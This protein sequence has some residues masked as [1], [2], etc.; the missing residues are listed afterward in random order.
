MKNQVIIQVPNKIVG[1]LKSVKLKYLW[2]LLILNFILVIFY[3]MNQRVPYWNT[4]Y[5][6]TSRIQNRQF[7]G[8]EKSYDKFSFSS[9]KTIFDSYRTPG[10]PLFIR[11]HNFL[12]SDYKYW[13]HFQ[14]AIYLASI[15]I[16]FG[17]MNVFGFDKYF[18]F[19]TAV[20]L[21]WNTQGYAFL[22]FVMTETLA[23][24]FMNIT[25][26]ALLLSVKSSKWIYQI[27]FA[28]TLFYMYQIRPNMSYVAFLV[29]FW[30]VCFEAVCKGYNFFRLKRT[31]LRFVLLSIFPLLIFGFIRYLY[32]GRYG[33]TT[34]ALGTMSG[35]AT[36]YLNEDNVLKL[37]G[38]SR[39]IADEILRR[40]RKMRLSYPCNLAPFESNII[41]NQSIIETKSNCFTELGNLSYQVAIKY[42]SGIE[43]FDDPEKNI[44]VWRYIPDEV[45]Y[46]HLKYYH[47]STDRLLGKYITDM[48]RIEWRKWIIMLIQTNIYGLALLFNNSMLNIFYVFCLIMGILW[49][50]ILPKISSGKFHNPKWQKYLFAYTFFT[51]TYFLTG[52]IL[53]M[54]FA[55]PILRYNAVIFPL[56]FQTFIMW[57]IPPIRLTTRQ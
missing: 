20:I 43:P 6:D 4:P 31:F 56:L 37:T 22:P 54:C 3:L 48:F 5:F 13:P 19:I 10:L 24:S 23:L 50:L 39:M 33:F 29:P 32:V 52:F 51:S 21:S 17:S 35:N 28:L 42:E 55:T 36:Y 30:A 16:L 12:F 41:P 46:F 49:N 34:Q 9:P 8:D 53:I 2:L 15:L 11:I 25:I 26:A 18:S 44:E 1:F 57:I 40:K 47:T 38:K 45:A 27:L 14:L 7:I